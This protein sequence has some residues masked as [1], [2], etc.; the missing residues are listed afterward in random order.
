MSAARLP[1][2]FIES[3]V[4]QMQVGDEG[5]TTPWAMWVD[6]DRQCWI[7]PRYTI[8]PTPSGTVQLYVLRTAAGVH[9]GIPDG[10]RYTPQAQHGFF[11][12]TDID[13]LPVV[14]IGTRP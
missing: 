8:H 9:V 11:P 14:S 10:K 2:A 3:T 5:Y 6:L 12:F 1:D 7:H 13:F 4:D